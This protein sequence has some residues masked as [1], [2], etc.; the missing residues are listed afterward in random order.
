MAKSVT[1]ILPDGSSGT[2]AQASAASG[3]PMQALYYR[4]YNDMPL[5]APVRKR[6]TL[7]DVDGVERD[8]SALARKYGI[9]GETLRTRDKNG[10]SGE[11][12]FAKTDYRASKKDEKQ[13]IRVDKARQRIK[14]ASTWYRIG[15]H[16]LLYM[17]GR[18]GEWVRSENAEV[19]ASFKRNFGIVIKVRKVVKVRE[20]V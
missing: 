8:L 15:V 10:L 19:I 1:V 9:D 17:R 3:I 12:L 7:M 5:Y 2:I 16:G 6:F 20:T 18:D 14:Y 11:A 13:Y 4:H